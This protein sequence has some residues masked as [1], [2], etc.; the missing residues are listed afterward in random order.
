MRIH[1]QVCTYPDASL[2]E[3]IEVLSHCAPLRTCS[4][5]TQDAVG[6][7]ASPGGHSLWELDSSFVNSKTEPLVYF[8]TF[9]RWTS[10]IDY[11]I[12]LA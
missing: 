4:P 2:N 3:S 7:D 10:S 11:S 5:V 1:S 8:S 12:A 6:V 9:A